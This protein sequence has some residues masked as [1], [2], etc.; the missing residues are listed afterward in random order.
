M[1]PARKKGDMLIIDCVASV[2]LY[3]YCDSVPLWMDTIRADMTSE[4]YNAW[5]TGTVSDT[6]YSTVVNHGLI[7]FFT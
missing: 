1:D 3:Y 7:D 2:N 5:Y 4:N 6:S